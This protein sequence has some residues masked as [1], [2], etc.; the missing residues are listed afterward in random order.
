MSATW[1]KKIMQN[2]SFRTVSDLDTRTSKVKEN[3]D[4]IY[5]ME[6]SQNYQQSIKKIKLLQHLSC[7]CN[8]ISQYGFGAN[9]DRFSSKHK[10]NFIL[11]EW[12]LM[13]I[14]RIKV[15]KYSR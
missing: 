1:I 10:I 3:I 8:N 9:F 15:E 11:S 2:F 5:V 7:S 12:S 6:E 14:L 13:V 4:F